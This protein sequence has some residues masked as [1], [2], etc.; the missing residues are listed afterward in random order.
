MYQAKGFFD[1]ITC[2]KWRIRSFTLSPPPKQ[3]ALSRLVWTPVQVEDAISFKNTLMKEPRGFE[4]KVW[5]TSWRVLWRCKLSANGFLIDLGGLLGG[6]MDS[7]ACHHTIWNKDSTDTHYTAKKK[8]FLSQTGENINLFL[9][10]NCF[11]GRTSIRFS[12]RKYVYKLG[13]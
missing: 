1:V 11:F 13:V 8:H 10:A 7:K 4:A 3:S 2:G 5:K 9:F 12:R 6:E